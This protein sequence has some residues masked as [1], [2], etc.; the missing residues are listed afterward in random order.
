MTLTIGDTVRIK[1]LPAV[2][3]VVAISSGAKLRRWPIL[4]SVPGHGD[5]AFALAE[6]EKVPDRAFAPLPKVMP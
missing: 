1:S 6:L 3:R 5:R 2:G 4:V